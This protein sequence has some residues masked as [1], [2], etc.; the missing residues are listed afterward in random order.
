MI[1]ML[2]FKALDRGRG[3]QWRKRFVWVQVIREGFGRRKYFSW[4][5]KC[6]SVS[7][8]PRGRRAFICM[9]QGQAQAVLGTGQRR[10]A[11][12]ECTVFGQIR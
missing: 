11:L 6:R 10:P 2:R 1:Y 8:C 4:A 5:L 12:L 3:S 7:S 9:Q